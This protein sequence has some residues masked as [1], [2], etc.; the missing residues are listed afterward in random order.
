MQ[1]PFGIAGR[2][3]SESPPRPHFFARQEPS[4]PHGEPPTTSRLLESLAIHI[5]LPMKSY[6]APMLEPSSSQRA[7]TDS[8][9]LERLAPMLT[10]EGALLDRRQTPDGFAPAPTMN[11]EDGPGAIGQAYNCDW[12]EQESQGTRDPGLG[13]KEITRRHNQGETISTEHIGKH[14]MMT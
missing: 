14:A 6:L 7:P 3:P 11:H 4:R 13:C 10:S 9:L 1:G 5:V 8:P 12:D 2:L